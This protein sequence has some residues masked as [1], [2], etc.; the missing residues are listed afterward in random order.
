MGTGT[1]EMLVE[2]LV[3]AKAEGMRLQ[4]GRAGEAAAQAVR[5]QKLVGWP[6]LQ[7]IRDGGRI[8]P[9]GSGV[10]RELRTMRERSSG[11]R[12]HRRSARKVFMAK[13]YYMPSRTKS[14]GKYILN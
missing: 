1:P 13:L 3:A 6:S 8:P 9:R 11:R 10:W 7:G 14:I 2:T 5:P 4:R 12:T